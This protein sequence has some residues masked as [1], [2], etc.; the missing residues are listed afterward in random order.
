MRPSHSIERTPD[1][2]R[3]SVTRHVNVMQPRSR[4]V[5]PSRVLDMRT[6]VPAKNYALSKQFY[7]DLGFTI[8]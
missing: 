3:R 2:L 8:N 7:V 6:F 5:E 1:R 4:A